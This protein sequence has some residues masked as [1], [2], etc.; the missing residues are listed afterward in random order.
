MYIK[1][2]F[3]YKVGYH[4]YSR[5]THSRW[6]FLLSRPNHVIRS[7]FVSRPLVFGFPKKIQP[8]IRTNAFTC[9]HVHSTRP[10]PLDSPAQNNRAEG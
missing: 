1:A 9:N 7:D 2:I 5:S 4:Y 8:L 3:V 10:K 6:H